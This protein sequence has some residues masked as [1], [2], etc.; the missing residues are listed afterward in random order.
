LQIAFYLPQFYPTPYNDEWWG[1]GFTEWRNVLRAS[2]LYE[3]H[4]Q[5]RIPADLGY[6]DLQHR[7]IRNKQAKLALAYGID[8]FAIW[9]Y[10]FPG[11]KWVNPL[12]VPLKGI[13]DDK[14]WPGKLCLAWANE[15]WQGKWHGLAQGKTLLTQE[16]LDVDRHFSVLEAAFRDTRYIRIDGQLLFLVKNPLDVPSE[17]L[18]ALR[19]KAAPL[20]GL[21][22]VGELDTRDGSKVTNLGLDGYYVS[23]MPGVSGFNQLPTKLD[24]TY[25]TEEKPDVFDY[26]SVKFVEDNHKRFFP[27]ISCG[28]DNTPRC[29]GDGVVLH[30][31][32]P[33]LFQENIR[34][35]KSLRRSIV[36]YKSW[37]EWAEGNYLEPDQYFG[38]SFL[39]KVRD[40]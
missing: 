31:A 37:N 3:G 36:F 16:Y 21:F 10:W 34:D 26:G 39:E 1:V 13:L 40:A 12:S 7:E 9:H 27:C 17:Y 8:G 19:D 4:L 28:F 29:N 20:G 2:I 11:Q 32:I 30:G 23:K 6:Y 5:P 24:V 15:S 14:G 18:F 35:A 25:T 22:I 33:E 38:K